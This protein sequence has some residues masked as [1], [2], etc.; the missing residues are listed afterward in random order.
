MKFL[1]GLIGPPNPESVS[2]YVDSVQSAHPTA[3]EQVSDTVRKLARA[4]VATGTTAVTTPL[5]VPETALH[6][7][8][9]VLSAPSVLL[10]KAGS[11]VNKT[12][13]KV[14]NTLAGKAD[15]GTAA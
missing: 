9:N 4:V 12:R 14:Y 2:K 10:H 8:G 7:A 15:Y 5:L 3:L 13:T 6:L 1:S 11:L